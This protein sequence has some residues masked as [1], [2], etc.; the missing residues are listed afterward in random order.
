M[1]ER[2]SDATGTLPLTSSAKGSPMNAA[3]QIPA[4]QLAAALTRSPK[5]VIR[6]AAENLLIEHG[7]WLRRPDFRSC[8]VYDPE[9]DMALINW[10]TVRDF[11]DSS[12][13]ASSSE[14][15]ILD[16][17][18]ALGEDRYLIDAMGHAHRFMIYTAL[19]AALGRK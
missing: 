2:A 6:T 15:A 19:T 12:P 8:V 3:A 13:R 10:G 14:L 16:L 17:A 9:D 7:F 18:C 11:L 5:N 4:D 1:D